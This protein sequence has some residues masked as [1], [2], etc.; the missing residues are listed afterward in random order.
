[1]PPT[2]SKD[3]TISGKTIQKQRQKNEGQKHGG[4]VSSKYTGPGTTRSRKH[5]SVFHQAE[6]AFAL[7]AYIKIRLRKIFAF[8]TT[9]PL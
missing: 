6:T 7:S 9:L 5:F 1:M 2:F 3:K 8:K 4:R